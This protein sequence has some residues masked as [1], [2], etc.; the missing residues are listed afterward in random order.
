MSKLLLSLTLKLTYG[1]WQTKPLFR[2]SL[3]EVADNSCCR[4][5]AQAAE[6]SEL[7]QEH[8]ESEGWDKI[9]RIY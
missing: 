2:T 7:G 1:E 8:M 3:V 9:P 5:M 6:D 4:W